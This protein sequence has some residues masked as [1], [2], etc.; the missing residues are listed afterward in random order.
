[1]SRDVDL[2]FSGPPTAEAARALL[3]SA[4]QIN[5]QGEGTIDEPAKADQAGFNFAFIPDHEMEP[6]L[7]IPFDEYPYELSI[8][9]IAPRHPSA[10]EAQTALALYLR[11]VLRSNG[12]RCIVVDSLQRVLE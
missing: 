3:A 1:M 5:V 6:D 10:A 11:D 8:M 2:F 4:L 7:G 9:P 12:V